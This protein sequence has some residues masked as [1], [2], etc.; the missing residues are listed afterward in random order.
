MFLGERRISLS[1]MP[2]RRTPVSTSLA[3]SH[4]LVSGNPRSSTV[5][6]GGQLLKA[7]V[8]RSSFLAGPSTGKAQAVSLHPQMNL[9]T[10]LSLGLGIQ[11]QEWELHGRRA[12]G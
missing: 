1:W 5:G 7:I 8:R 10:P 11:I 3:S 4:G 2:R 6:C 9:S 12:N